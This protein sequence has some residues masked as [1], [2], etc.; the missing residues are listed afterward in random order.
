MTDMRYQK[1]ETCS[2]CGKVKNCLYTPTGPFQGK[3]ICLE[4]ERNYGDDLADLVKAA[5]KIQRVEEQAH[6]PERL[7]S[8]GP[9][10]M[11][12]TRPTAEQVIDRLEKRLHELLHRFAQVCPDEMGETCREDKQRIKNARAALDL[13]RKWREEK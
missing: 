5:D 10:A 6:F 7:F 11:T 4:C 2:K 3:W 8:K 13:A 1:Q 12:T 9:K